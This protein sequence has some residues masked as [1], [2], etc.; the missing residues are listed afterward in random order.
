M[1]C[2]AP[3][4][5]VGG[6]TLSTS[7]FENAKELIDKVSGDGGDPTLD[8]YTE[9]IAN[10]NNTK[11]TSGIQLPSD[12]AGQPPVQTTLP[13]PSPI[14]AETV[15]TAPPPGGNGSGVFPSIWG[16]DY[17]ALLSP[18]FK[19]RAF[20]IN[21]VFP[22]ELIDYNSTYTKDVR[23]NNLRAL[24]KNVAEPLLVKFGTF[25]INSGIRNKTSTPTGL[26]QHI[27]GQGVDIQFPGWSY[28]RYWDNAAWVKDNIMY[29]Q[30][31][32]EHSDKTGLAWYHLSFNASGN[33]AAT[34]RTKVMTMYR[35]H[36]D[37][38]LRRYG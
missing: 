25:N 8:E 5:T 21:A 36:Y 3:T 22:N 6:V 15:N 2:N 32:F 1:A 14:A 16:G 11:Q 26:S 20:T 30:F 10:G 24:A 35:N 13:T 28:S 34:D 19:V 23:Y 12:P 9:N 31:I 29:D 38:G 27:T 18:N 33:R 4:I 17:D 37:Q 7:D